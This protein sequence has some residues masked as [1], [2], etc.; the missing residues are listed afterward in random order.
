VADFLRD[1][2]AAGEE[3]E[4]LR[5]DRIDLFAQG[6]EFVC[7]CLLMIFGSRHAS[8]DALRVG[9]TARPSTRSTTHAKPARQIERRLDA[10]TGDPSTL[11]AT[12]AGQPMPNQ[13]PANSF[14]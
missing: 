1:L 3:F 12:A 11:P 8:D 9:W 4:D 14:K 13:R 7:H 5:V 10:W 2:A 6:F